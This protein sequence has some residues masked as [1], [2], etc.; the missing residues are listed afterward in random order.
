MEKEDQ[1]K[2]ERAKRGYVYLPTAS[3]RLYIGKAGVTIINTDKLDDPE[4]PD[5]RGDLLLLSPVEAVQ[6][7]REILAHASELEAREPELE[8]Q[9]EQV[10]QVLLRMFFERWKPDKHTG[11]WF[12][13]LDFDKQLHDAYNRLVAN[14][15][16]LVEQWY[17]S[18]L[19]DKFSYEQH[20]ALFW[21]YFHRKYRDDL[22]E[23][24]FPETSEI[25]A[26]DE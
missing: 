11:T 7:A 25:E 19:T 16:G 21:R 3:H 26:D 4:D 10:S 24:C 2:Q 13:S 8:E 12:N 15:G 23:K 9:Y 18:T 1:D 20:Q 22:I 17:H 14:Q 5:P 6:M